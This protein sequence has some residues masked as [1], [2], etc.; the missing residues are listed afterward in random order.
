M[1]KYLVTKDLI[2]KPIKVKKMRFW[3]ARLAMTATHD[4]I[5]GQHL[6]FRALARYFKQDFPANNE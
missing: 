5:C 2:S 4:G 6:G 3:G 1:K